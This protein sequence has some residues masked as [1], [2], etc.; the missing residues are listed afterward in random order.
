MGQAERVMVVDIGGTNIRAAVVTPEGNI[1]ARSQSNTPVGASIEQ[2]FGVIAET[3]QQTGYFFDGIVFGVPGII[4]ANGVVRRSANLS[5]T[6]ISFL[7]EARAHWRCPVIMTNDVR[8]HT[9]GES[10]FGYGRGEDNPW[11]HAVIGT[12][13]AV[14]LV[15][16][17]QIVKGAH[18]AAGELGH[19]PLEPG[20]QLC[21]CGKR[22]CV[23]TVCSG[24]AIQ[25]MKVAL[26]AVDGSMGDVWGNFADKLAQVMSVV[27]MWVDPSFLVLS[28]G[29]VGDYLHWGRRFENAY[30]QYVM[31]P[32]LPEPSIKI[33]KLGQ[34]APFLGGVSLFCNGAENT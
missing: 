8:L 5:W 7:D 6:N 14:N 15:V 20:G 18:N 12:G 30:K 33:S 34:D 27:S 17:G 1:L 2:F 22:G 26:A 11:I 31:R 4:D 13:I 32:G 23:E 24:S 3:V 9:I 28:G 29:V 16:N 21:G 10:R 25:R 19:A